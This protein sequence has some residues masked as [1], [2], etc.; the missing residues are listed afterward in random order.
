MCPLC[1]HKPRQKS[2]GRAFSKARRV[3]GQ[4]PESPLAS[5]EIPLSSVKGRRGELSC[6][7]N[8]RGE[9]TRSEGFSFICAQILYTVQTASTSS[10]T[11]DFASQNVSLRERDCHLPHGGRL[12]ETNFNTQ[13][14]T[15]LSVQTTSSWYT[16]TR[17]ACT[18]I[19]YCLSGLPDRRLPAGAS[20]PPIY[21][22][23]SSSQYAK[24]PR[25]RYAS[26]VFFFIVHQPQLFA[27]GLMI[28][29][30]KNFCVSVINF[31]T[32]PGVT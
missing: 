2:F 15:N 27:V 30:L 19:D 29:L 8:S 7:S 9:P 17:F 23:I 14:N 16:Q 4:R 21:Y 20:P 31:C 25:K 6:Q 32:R 28:S 3:L 5:G 12:M 26:A 13:I 18:N 10:V 22:Q 1:S 24:T 11:R